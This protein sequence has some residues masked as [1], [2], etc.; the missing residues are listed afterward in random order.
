[1]SVIPNFPQPTLVSANG[2]EIEV[3]EA[4]QKNKGNPIV[5]CH[6]WPEHAFS[7]RHQIEA[8]AAAGFHVITPNQR[9]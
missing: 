1:M 4:G 5:L 2:I 8:L 7:W 3:F 6:G 9:G